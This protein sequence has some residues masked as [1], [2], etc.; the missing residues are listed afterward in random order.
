MPRDARRFDP[1]LLDAAFATIE[2]GVRS[3]DLP[4]GV[5]AIATGDRTLRLEAF[6]P[7]K[8]DSIFLLASITKPIFATALM[9]LVERGRMRLN[10]PVAAVIPEFGANGKGDVRLWH[11][12]THTSGLDETPGFALWGQADRAGLTAAAI[13]APLRF[14][15]GSQY[16]YCNGSF[17]VMA[18]LIRRLGGRDDVAYLRDEVLEPLGMRDT[19]Y[20]PAASP[21]L[22]P[23]H[24]SPWANDP[25]FEYL[26]SLCWGAAGLSSTAKD[27]IRFGQAFLAGG[28]LDGKRVLAPATVRAMTS[29]QTDGLLETRAAGDGPPYYGLGFGKAGP[30][31]ATGPSTELRT[32][33][34]FGHGGATGT[35]LWVEPEL[36]LVFAFLTNKWGL[37]APYAGRALNAAVAA[38]STAV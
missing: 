28:V 5:L 18:E 2:E 21:R 37:D 31:N 4:S 22:A 11:L 3:G 38:A 34:G 15:P 26:R 25:H 20:Q 23:V 36:D 7:V 13:Q 30:D 33:A 27:L 12:L 9:R 24:G 8:T 14:R 35:L 10:D 29:L 6:G 1:E 17:F 19:S 16:A 32:P